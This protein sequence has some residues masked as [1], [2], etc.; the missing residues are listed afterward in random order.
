MKFVT[1]IMAALHASGG[2]EIMVKNVTRRPRVFIDFARN[3]EQRIHRL[4][5]AAQYHLT[6]S[7]VTS[8]CGK[9]LPLERV[10]ERLDSCCLDG[11]ILTHGCFRQSC[12]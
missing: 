11:P 10:R 9:I 3:E 7:L 5:V 12:P 1:R 8:I 6:D 4:L 2:L